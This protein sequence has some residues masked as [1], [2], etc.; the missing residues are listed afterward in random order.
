ML[1]K[2][3][4]NGLAK[5]LAYMNASGFL[6]ST[7]ITS[8]LMGHFNVTRHAMASTVIKATPRLEAYVRNEQK[9]PPMP[10]DELRHLHDR[11]G[12]YASGIYDTWAMMLRE[13]EPEIKK[14]GVSPALLWK[15]LERCKPILTSLADQFDYA[16]LS[17]GGA[18]RFADVSFGHW[19]ERD[20]QELRD[21]G[22][23]VG[24]PDGRFHGS[25]KLSK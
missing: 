8:G 23:L 16:V 12:L 18:P 11:R 25:P 13:F 10:D 17:R 4:Y 3:Q 22:I 9:Y 6:H 2:P 7:E 20:I 14:L 15:Q 5:A 1:D 21:A 19:A 24:Y